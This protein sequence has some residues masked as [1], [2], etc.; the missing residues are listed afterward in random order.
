M[1]LKF[2]VVFI[3]LFYF[4]FSPI[5]LNKTDAAS[6]KNSRPKIPPILLS[7]VPKDRGVLLTWKEASDPLTHYL[8]AYGRSATE[9]E[10][11]NPNV[12]PKGTTAYTINELTN[13]VKYY[14]KVRGE[15]GCKPG[16][17][18]NKLSAIPGYAPVK[19]VSQ[20]NL[21]IYKTVEGAS[22]SATP[23]EELN[24]EKAPPPDLQAII[25]D[26]LANCST[27]QGLKLL[28]IEFVILIAYLYL[29]GRFSL[30]KHIY[31]VI[32]PFAIY[33][34][35]SKING[36]CPSNSFVCKYFL[37]LN[38]VLFMATIILYK[39]KYINIKLNLLQHL[40]KKI[41]RKL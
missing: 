14:F 31:A 11:G 34:F 30:F 25:N 21:S 10:Y 29:A 20:P 17:F 4:L 33:I 23:T 9:I 27:C 1:R 24:E 16:K 28:I 15:N 22:A 19:T 35:F 13:G 7:A 5:A 2:F 36:S 37:Q 12:G 6:C 3:L 41:K 8:V 18:S 26:E 38:I 40:L 39:N 32:V